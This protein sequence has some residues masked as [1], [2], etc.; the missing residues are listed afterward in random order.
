MV[1][2][3]GNFG[4]FD[5]YETMEL[6]SF[7][8]EP[9]DRKLNAEISGKKKKD[10]DIYGDEF[11]PLDVEKELFS[12]KPVEDDEIVYIEKVDCMA[13]NEFILIDTEG[14]DSTTEEISNSNEITKPQTLKKKKKVKKETDDC[15]LIDYEGFILTELTEFKKPVPRR[16]DLKAV[17]D[18]RY[19]F[20]S[21]S[22]R[23]TTEEDRLLEIEVPFDVRS[24]SSTPNPHSE[25]GALIEEINHL[26]SQLLIKSEVEDEGARS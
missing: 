12:K 21:F 16:P 14:N 20:K 10:V 11:S 24:D 15:L 4:F 7:L 19:P 3:P 23:P 26:A 13:F 18:F 2:P 8:Q 25:S 1:T 22:Q 9:I 17:S 5:P 6:A